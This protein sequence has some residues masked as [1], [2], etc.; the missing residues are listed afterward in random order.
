M[1][2]DIRKLSHAQQ[3]ASQ[4]H[5]PHQEIT[6]TFSLG[7]GSIALV[8]ELGREVVENSSIIVTNL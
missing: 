6:K 7:G 4:Q 1:H 8:A 2:F 3:L 5:K